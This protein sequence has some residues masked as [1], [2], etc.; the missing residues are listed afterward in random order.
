MVGCTSHVNL[1]MGVMAH[2]YQRTNWHT[3]NPVILVSLSKLQV[4]LWHS[5]L[6]KNQ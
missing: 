2:L 6:G 3:I 1:T 4:F 5:C